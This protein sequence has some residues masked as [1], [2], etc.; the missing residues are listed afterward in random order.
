MDKLELKAQL[1]VDDAGLV[2]GVAWPFGSAD[3]VGDLITPGAFKGAPANLPMLWAHDQGQAV[4]VW[5]SV[6]ETD[7][8]LEVR[9]RLLIDDVQRAREVRAL[10]REGA[11]N[12][13]SIG[14]SIIDAVARKGGGRSISKLDL[15][16][17]S[18]V[19]VPC[20]PG[21]RITTA[22]AAGAA[23]NQ[24]S[25]VDNE[26]KG[27]APD[28]AAIQAQL[29]EIELKL[30]R[31]AV[32]KGAN[33]NAGQDK[34]VEVKAFNAFARHGVERMGADEAKAL[35]VSNDTAGGYLVPEA[36][37]GEIDKLLVQ[38]SPVRSLARVASASVGEVIL[39]KKTGSSTA[40][41]VGE[42]APRS[43]TQPAYGSQ[44]IGIFELAC[45][46]DVSN[47]LL[48]DSAFDIESEL[49]MDLAEEFGRAEGLAFLNGDGT[50]KPTGILR[51]TDVPVV[52][53]GASLDANDLIDLFH[54]LPSFYA[55][56]GVWGLNRATMGIVRK[57]TATD[58][59]YLWQEAISEGN[60]A[61]ILG[62]PV[63]E[64][65]DMPNV[66]AGAIPIAFGDFRQGFR[67]FD[68]TGVSLLRDPYSVQTSGQVRFHA[69]RRVGGAVTKA[70]AL[71]FLKIAA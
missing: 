56:S 35:N 70:E 26:T 13:L 27:A 57:M 68:R 60:P 36:M 10:V 14:F 49:S 58:G 44:T 22:K 15:V 61:T 52:D 38:F 34:A 25:T 50:L 8:G 42:T 54:S 62:R 12:G 20:H 45:Y 11:A 28:L 9:G 48:E 40:S 65:P 41:W 33:D 4:G 31:P 3:R 64:L 53:A 43:A 51:N 2:A 19:P 69:R 46:V 24:E 66:A 29:T 37:L 1:T 16:E 18:V 67:I 59:R 21:A 23:D 17:I 5:D 71:R 39:P 32:L 30:N 63:V 47:R 7:A 55:N 6:T